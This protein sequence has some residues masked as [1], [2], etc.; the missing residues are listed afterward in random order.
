MTLPKRL[1]TAACILTGLT[2]IS[3]AQIFEYSYTPEYFPNDPLTV[4]TWQQPLAP[5]NNTASVADGVLTIAAD[6]PEGYL[7][8]RQTIS[9]AWTG[10]ASTVEL[11]LRVESQ[12]PEQAWTQGVSINIGAYGL[13][14]VFSTSAVMYGALGGE[15][16]AYLL[17]TT[18]VHSYWIAASDTGIANL[19][20]DRNPVPVMTF[21]M[22]S[23]AGLNYMD[24]GATTPFG[25]GTVEWHSVSWTNG[26]AFAPVPEPA[27]F[28]LIGLAV[29][30]IIPLHRR[31]AKRRSA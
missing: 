10:G 13:N 5:V 25:A 17:D 20:V 28:A 31:F 19:Y 23:A 7:F 15:Y 1:A 18:E 12:L 27:S 29:F 11:V 3:P 24:F 16:Q 8:Y 22:V 4:P 30:S 9:E 26:S 2:Q 6:A 14:L 21:E